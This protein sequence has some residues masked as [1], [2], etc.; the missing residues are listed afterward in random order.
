MSPRDPDGEVTYTHCPFCALNCGLGL[1]VRDGRPTGTVRWKEAPLTAGAL[2]AK[3]A[4]AYQQVHHPHRLTTPLVR[5][6]GELRQVTWEEA[7]DAAAD[8][9][10][11]LRE[12]HGPE[13]NAVLGG[14]SLTNEK[15]YLIGK[16]ARL[17]LRTPH[18]DYNGR[19]CMSSAGLASRLAFGLDRA[20]TPLSDLAR[21]DVAVILGANLS[22]SFPVAIPKLLDRLRRSGGTVIVVDPRG[23]RFVQPQDLHLRLRPGTDGVVANAILAELARQG[24][25]ARDF[26]D[27]RTTGF[28][29]ALVA[30][31]SMELDDAAHVADVNEA[32]LRSVAEIIGGAKRAIYLFARGVDHHVDGV[33]NVLAWI[34]VALARGHV[35][36]VG[37]G[38]NMLT[39]QRNGQGGREM[40]QRCDQLPGARSIEDPADRDVVARRWG[41]DPEALPR[42]GASYLDIIEKAG[43]G[44]VRGLM[45]M[46]SNPAVAS[47]DRGRTVEHLGR[48]EHLV[49]IDPFVSETAAM[50]DVVLP[51]TT[52][53]EEEGTVTTLE[54]RVIR[55]DAAVAPAARRSDIDVI[56]SLAWRLGAER[57]LFAFGHGRAVFEEIRRVTAGAPAD[58]SGMTWESLRD[59]GGICWP[60]P[61]VGH[62]GTPRL[63]TERFAHPDGR[64]RFTAVAPRVP[65]TSP[66]FPLVLITGRVLPQY[67]T[68]V[69]TRR[70][71]ELDRRCPEP[72]LEVHPETAADLAL[73]EGQ[74][75]QVT[76]R[77]GTVEVAWQP[78]PNL[79]RD[80][81]F[82]PFHWSAANT[83]VAG[84]LDPRSRMPG[85]KHTPVRVAPAP[86]TGTA[87]AGTIAMVARR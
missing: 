5:I 10:A 41:V 12:R 42:S 46:C 80:T 8:G 11:G 64:A 37:C 25:L 40:G 18:V 31:Q 9:F 60:C 29:E 79:R 49:V 23:S 33:T 6:G 85:F 19:L 38:I 20:M 81:V 2:C 48:L 57:R 44:E 24:R 84:D 56:R 14:S 68:A 45:V 35:G 26:I 74:P 65:E 55:C 50:A 69:Q 58:Y 76:S 1:T 7:L 83:L 54:G 3:G 39:G 86:G 4:E 16:F 62:P 71:P 59:R 27:G 82:L 67:L 30:A 87:C 28:E 43:T 32:D 53:A 78:Q 70:I 51:G 21:T 15:C 66:E 13:T 22:A 47:P 77:V 36:R 17:A 75:V 61:E 63:F 72:V 52:F 34:N 73:P